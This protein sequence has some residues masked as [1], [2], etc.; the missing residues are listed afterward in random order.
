MTG[1]V[2]DDAVAPRV[3][4]PDTVWLG[5]GLVAETWRVPVATLL[6]SAQ[7]TVSIGRDA[8]SVASSE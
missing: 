7:N 1:P 8:V 2:T 5:A 6:A 4:A 3:V